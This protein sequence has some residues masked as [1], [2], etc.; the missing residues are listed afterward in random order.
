VFVYTSSPAKFIRPY[1]PY[2]EQIDI[3]LSA[4]YLYLL[5][6][7]ADSYFKIQGE[8]NIDIIT[9]KLYF[10]SGNDLAFRRYREKECDKQEKNYV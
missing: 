10:R 7:P 6:S 4:P 3:Q 2:S 1:F 5:L 9:G 8:R